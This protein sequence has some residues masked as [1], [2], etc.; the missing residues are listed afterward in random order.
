[1]ICQLCNP[2][3][4]SVPFATERAGYEA[5]ERLDQ[6]M[7]GLRLDAADIDVTACP[8]VVR[9]STDCLAIGDAEVVNALRFIRANAGRILQ[10]SDVVQA[11]SLSQCTLHTRFRLAVGRSVGKEINHQGAQYI[12]RLLIATDEPLHAI[13]RKLGYDTDAHLARYF[14]REMGETPR[15]YRQRR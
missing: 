14:R 15:A 1:M 9:Q 4:T 11:T 10:V 12:A 5:A 13:A 3:L 8:I 7:H 6:L 2:P